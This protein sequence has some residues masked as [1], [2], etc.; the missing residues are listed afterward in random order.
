MTKVAAS[1][2]SLV[3]STYL[4]GSDP[5]SGLAIAVDAAGSAYVTGDTSS[6]DFPTTP[7]AFDTSQS[8]VFDAFV[9]KLSAV[10]VVS[11]HIDIKP[12]SAQNP[13]NLGSHGLI[14]VAILIDAD[15]RRENGC[16]D[17]RLLRRRRECEP[18]RLHRGA[19]QAT[20]GG[21]QRRR[22]ARPPLPLRGQ[23]DGD[24]SGRHNRLPDRHHPHR[25]PRRGLRLDQDRL[26]FFKPRRT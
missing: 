23:G 24:R 7:G 26:R 11:V 9:T 13:I 16:R 25:G 12:G 1:G 2:A 8:G 19:R 17:E 20:R 3:Y 21:R 22:S 14:P 10:A 15:L 6:A 4:G 18:T 5:D